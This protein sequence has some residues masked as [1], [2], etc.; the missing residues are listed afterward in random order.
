MIEILEIGVGDAKKPNLVWKFLQSSQRGR[1]RSSCLS[2]ANS[3]LNNMK[4]EIVQE[5]A[6]QMVTLTF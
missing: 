1:V 4:S 5:Q 2:F 3:F 6:P